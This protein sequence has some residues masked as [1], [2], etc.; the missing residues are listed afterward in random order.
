MVKRAIISLAFCLSLTALKAQEVE[1]VPLGDFENW[2]V[3]DIQESKIIGGETKRI[4]NIAPNDTIVGNVPFLTDKSIWATS[5]TFAKV[6]GV[7]KASKSAEPADGPTGRCAKLSSCWAS[8]KAMG[9]V[10]INVLVSGSIYW[11]K[12][13]EP[14]TS[15]KNPYSYMDWGIPFTRRPKAILM[16]MNAIVPNTG[17]LTK[18]TTS[19]RV[20]FEGYD[21]P[22]IM[23]VLQHRW[24]DEQ[25]NIHAYRVGTAAGRIKESTNGWVKAYRVPVQYGECDAEMQEVMPLNREARPFHATNSKGQ[26]KRIIEE[27][28]DGTKP[29]THAILMIT[30]GQ[31]GAFVGATDNVLYL[32]NISLEY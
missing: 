1:L 17:I 15:T 26:S 11:G 28:F 29:V 13:F 8:C 20:D 16:D 12:A 6:A 4:Y 27:G 22:E 3:R 32:D 19:K 31:H 30:T 9:I 18:G 23:F 10:D 25:G 7:I 24:E 5:N 14:V 2:V 21:H